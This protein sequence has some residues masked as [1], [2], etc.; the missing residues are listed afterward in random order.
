LWIKV[1]RKYLACQKFSVYIRVS[2]IVTSKGMQKKLRKTR[3]RDSETATRVKRTADLVGVSTY[4]VWRVIRGDSVNE[5]IMETYMFLLEGE[6]NLLVEAV[7]NLV[8]IE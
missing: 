4:H 5:K 6:Q 2:L 7:K 8:P 3:G 1:C